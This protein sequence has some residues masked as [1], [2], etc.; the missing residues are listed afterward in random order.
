[1]SFK[2]LVAVSCLNW[3]T[4]ISTRTR[5]NSRYIEAGPIE[6]LPQEVCLISRGDITTT[7]AYIH[8]IHDNHN[9]LSDLRD[10]FDNPQRP[11]GDVLADIELVIVHN[12]PLVVIAAAIR[13]R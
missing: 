12:H 4:R 11:I 7:K 2:P 8:Y 6:L 10:L 3:R 5:K 1:M 9:E 13:E